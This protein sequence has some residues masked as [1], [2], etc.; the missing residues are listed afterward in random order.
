[1]KHKLKQAQDLVAEYEK[2]MNFKLKG[3]SL[4]CSHAEI[5][6]YL[7]SREDNQ[8]RTTMVQIAKEVNKTKSTITQLTDK[9]IRMNLITKAQSELDKRQV[10]VVLTAKGY[11]S[12]SCFKCV[13]DNVIN[14][15][16]EAG[17]FNDWLVIK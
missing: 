11:D 8:D 2:R 3:T 12:G 1:M 16:V 17:L 4:V 15:M 9:L 5:L 7:K 6:I 10:D 14:D 13:K